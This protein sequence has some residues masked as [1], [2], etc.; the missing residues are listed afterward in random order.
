MRWKLSSKETQKL[1]QHEG[2]PGR[3]ERGPGPRRV[4]ECPRPELRVGREQA[5]S[6]D[7]EDRIRQVTSVNGD[8]DLRYS[9][10]YQDGS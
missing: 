2:P 1:I 7:D 9:Y 5:V 6:D 3:P 10:D 4:Q 8:D